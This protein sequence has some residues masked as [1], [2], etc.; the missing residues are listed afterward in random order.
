M[1][2]ETLL[3]ALQERM[4]KLTDASFTH[5]VRN[6]EL[7]A[8]LERAKLTDAEEAALEAAA[9]EA[10]KQLADEICALRDHVNDLIRGHADGTL[11]AGLDAE[12]SE[13]E[14]NRAGLER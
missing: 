5:A 3:R 2:N 6:A 7:R 9:T 11:I 13:L 12:L 10:S 14:D 8:A 4:R 1:I